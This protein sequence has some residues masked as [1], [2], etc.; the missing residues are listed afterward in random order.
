MS[1]LAANPS[2]RQLAVA[3]NSRKNHEEIILRCL[4]LVYR[5]EEYER[6]MKFFLNRFME[7]NRDPTD[8]RR[9]EFRQVFMRVAGQIAEVLGPGA[10]RPERGLN[11]AVTD[12]TVVGLAHR[13]NRGPVLDRT[14]LQAAHARLLSALNQA[15]LYRTGTTDEKRLGRRIELARALYGEVP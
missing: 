3:G 11:I 7:E 13:L 5:A 15:G 8:E 2:W 1:D 12:A 14:E 4:A 9:E 10:L 6:P